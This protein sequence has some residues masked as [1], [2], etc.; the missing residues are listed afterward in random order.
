M[1]TVPR[2]RE[3]K[4]FL[5][6]KICRD[7]DVPALHTFGVSLDDFAEIIAKSKVASSMKGNPINLTD[8]ELHS[9]L[10]SAL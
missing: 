3:I 7:L 1:S 8:D 6:R 5:A 4:E 2:H 9:I 10:A